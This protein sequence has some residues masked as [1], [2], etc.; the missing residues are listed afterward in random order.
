MAA[1][2]RVLK[3][4]LSNHSD[5]FD[6]F[7]ESDEV[8]FAVFNAENEQSAE[9]FAAVLNEVVEGFHLC[10]GEKKIGILATKIRAALS[11]V[12]TNNH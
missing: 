12:L 11:A 2:F 8:G 3:Q 9:T 7:V 6:V 5:V 4:T 1:E 10:V